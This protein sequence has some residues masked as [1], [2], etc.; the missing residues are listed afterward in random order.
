MSLDL[1]T[2]D[3]GALAT[4]LC[5]VQCD[6]TACSN[7]WHDKALVLNVCLCCVLVALHQDYKGLRSLLTGFFVV[8]GGGCAAS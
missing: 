2:P 6:L 7:G 8:T 4:Y 5:L 1:H 3:A